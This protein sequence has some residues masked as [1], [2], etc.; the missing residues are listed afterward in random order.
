[1]HFISRAVSEGAQGTAQALYATVASGVLMGVATL[2]SGWL[3]AWAGAHAYI[4]MAL[5]SAIGLA[6]ALYVRTR[7]D[8]GL[9]WRAEGA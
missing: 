9:L 8:G 3:Y 1:M 7:W 6:G 4:A 2:V 5:L